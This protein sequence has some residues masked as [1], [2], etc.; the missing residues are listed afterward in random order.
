MTTATI[1]KKD[2][3]SM[4]LKT[5]D[6]PFSASEAFQFGIDMQEMIIAIY[7]ELNNCRRRSALETIQYFQKQYERDIKSLTDYLLFTLNTEMGEFYQNQGR[8]FD[9]DFIEKEIAKTQLL[10]KRNIENYITKIQT[11]Y[12]DIELGEYHANAD[13]NEIFDLSM[14]LRNYS[15]ELYSR[16]AK[17]YPE[18]NIRKA[19]LIMA[20]IIDVGSNDLEFNYHN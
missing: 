1:I 2:L 12:N 18:G 17:L 7:T 14:E 15:S 3:T 11:I 6:Y 16:L 4:K 5:W 10:I 8:P 9:H 20:E 19:F 13:S